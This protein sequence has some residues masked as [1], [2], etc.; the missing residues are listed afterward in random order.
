MKIYHGEKKAKEAQENFIN[1]FSK[2]GVP[3]NVIEIS[4]KE[5]AKLVDVLLA[6]KIVSSKT[7]F[8]RLVG[9]GAVTDMNK[10]EKIKDVDTKVLKTV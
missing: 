8:R 6:E 3:E 2:G 10:N 9:E 5:D 1:T 4:C 7:E